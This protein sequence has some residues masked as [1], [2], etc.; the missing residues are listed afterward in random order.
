MTNTFVK[1][2]K[3]I[4]DFFQNKWFFAILKFQKSAKI[5]I[6]NFFPFFLL[7]NGHN[8]IFFRLEKTELTYLISLYLISQK[9][10]KMHFPRENRELCEN[11]ASEIFLTQKFEISDQKRIGNDIQTYWNL[12]SPKFCCPVYLGKVSLKISNLP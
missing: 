2:W 4:L 12:G 1:K 3:N 5:P 10:Q 11:W 7:Q 6:F 9:P 8:I